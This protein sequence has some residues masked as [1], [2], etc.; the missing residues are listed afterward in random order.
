MANP[1]WLGSA[2]SIQEVDTVTP[3]GSITTA[4]VNNIVAKDEAGNS[5]VTISFTTGGTT[6]V[7]AVSAGLV[8]AW[9]GNATAAAI[10]TA[11]GGVTN[12]TLTSLVSGVPMHITSSV[13]GS[14]TLTHAVGT[15]NSGPSDWGV[16][17][18]WSTGAVP[19]SSD[20]V[21]IDARGPANILYGLGQSAVTLASLTV[22]PGCPLIG[23]ASIP[24]SISATVLSIPKPINSLT[25]VKRLNIN[26]G[27]NA[28][29]ATIQYSASSG[30]DAGLEPIRINGVHTSNVLNVL[31]GIVGIGTNNPSDTPKFPIINV[32]G[33]TLNLGMGLQAGVT[34]TATS[35]T[36]NANNRPGGN[37]FTS[38]VLAGTNSSVAPTV[39]FSGNVAV[40]TVAA[41]TPGNGQIRVASSAQGTFTA[42]TPSFGGNSTLAFTLS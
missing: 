35:G 14:G 37:I 26:L 6:M 42:M 13:T 27:T 18:N 11:S 12:V 28:T 32:Y 9:N 15:A 34:L 31:N 38:L 40:F 41:I 16:A 21:L 4:D 25:G 19:V 2:S 8:A 23:Q 29:T 22:S 17:A 20:N 30:V 1:Y 5:L 3:G 24:L 10:A 39:D 36:V 33:G 7:A